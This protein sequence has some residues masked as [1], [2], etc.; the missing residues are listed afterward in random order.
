MQSRCTYNMNMKPQVERIDACKAD[1]L[2]LKPTALE[3]VVLRGDAATV[4]LAE[5]SAG[6]R[7]CAGASQRRRSGGGRRRS[8]RGRHRHPGEL[9]I[10]R[11]WAL[12]TACLVRWL[13]GQDMAPKC[14][15]VVSKLCSAPTLAAGGRCWAE[16]G[17]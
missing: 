1:N 10:A 7:T 8:Q 3:A 5:D 17:A 2:G 14:Q 12:T 13:Q 6:A 11:G 15:G 16:L 9:H 4:V